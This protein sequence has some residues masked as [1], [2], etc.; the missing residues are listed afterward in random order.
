ML[1]QVFEI[2]LGGFHANGQS[3]RSV[4]YY[5][6]QTEGSPI[7]DATVLAALFDSQFL[8]L[9]ED[10]LHQDWT[11]NMRE[12]LNLDDLA[13]YDYSF[14][15]VIGDLA[16]NSLPSVL[17]VG[18]R[19]KRQPNGVHRGRHNFPVGNAAFLGSYGLIDDTSYDSLYFLQQQL[20]E[21]LIDGVSG[22]QWRPIIIQKHY[23][24]GVFTGY[25]SRGN[26]AGQWQINKEFTTVKSRQGYA[27]LVAEE[28]A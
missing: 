11:I 9:L 22:D 14:A 23:S 26:V 2:I 1:N 16:G 10:V 25:T 21:Y 19:S 8:P 18:F 4:F 28:P 7:G 5:K 27:W 13:D 20:G 3:F 15:P 24:G 17:A 6:H 12:V